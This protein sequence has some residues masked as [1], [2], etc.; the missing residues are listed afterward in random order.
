V[1]S[2]EGRAAV[3]TRSRIVA[4]ISLGEAQRPTTI[5]LVVVSGDPEPI[6]ECAW[7]H[8]WPAD[9][10]MPAIAAAVAEQLDRDRLREAQWDPRTNPLHRSHAELSVFRA[11]C[12]NKK[13]SLVIDAT[14]VGERVFA[15]F[16]RVKRNGALD[17]DE[18]VAL[19]IT[20]GAK[21]SDCEYRQSA[22]WYRIPKNDLASAMRLPFETKRF[23]V[24]DSVP[25]A[26]R[27]RFEAEIRNF[28]GSTAVRDDLITDARERPDDDIL[29]AVASA[30]WLGSR[31]RVEFILIAE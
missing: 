8:R 1:R 26:L 6:F 10:T 11:E 19:Q 29:L 20:M 5:A 27:E 7:I 14:L 12:L 31:P 2:Q 13:P 18:L 9:V 15:E 16:E 23:K 22:R 21:L 24:L 4:G 3:E 30:L 17:V 25:K 28:R